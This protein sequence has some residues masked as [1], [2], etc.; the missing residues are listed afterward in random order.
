VAWLAIAALCPALNQVQAAM[1][2]P[3]ATAAAS[4][5]QVGV[6]RLGANGL[7]SSKGPLWVGVTFLGGPAVAAA[8]L[9]LGRRGQ[10]WPQRI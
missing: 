6:A 10:A 1:V 4:P 7:C 5:A 2:P 3:A 9:G 8:R